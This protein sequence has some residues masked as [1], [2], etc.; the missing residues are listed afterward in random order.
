ML[1][2]FGTSY[3]VIGEMP[4]EWMP[5]ALKIPAEEA[6]KAVYPVWLMDSLGIR[7]AIFV[8]CPN[9]KSP[10]GISPADGDEQQNWNKD[11]PTLRTIVGCARCSNMWMLTPDRAYHLQI[12][13]VPPTSRVPRPLHITEPIQPK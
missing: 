13:P 9:C 6:P 3:L 11:N 2:V 8:R 1:S 12:L 4:V 5:S 10:L 7:A